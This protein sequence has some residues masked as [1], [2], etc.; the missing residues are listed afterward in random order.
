MDD[1]LN[2]NNYLIEVVKGELSISH[3]TKPVIFKVLD[4]ITT[5]DDL[6]LGFY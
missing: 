3:A 5:V 6:K 1:L 4:V 2:I